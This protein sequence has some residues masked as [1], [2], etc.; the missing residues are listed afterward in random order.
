MQIAILNIAVLGLLVFLFGM[1]ASARPDNRLR[2]WEAGWV[3]VLVHFGVGI[4]NPADMLGAKI[5]FCASADTLVVAGIFFVVSTMVMREGVK[6]ALRVGSVMGIGTLV[7]IDLAIVAPRQTGI[8]AALAI[9]HLGAAGMVASTVRPRKQTVTR[10]LVMVCTLLTAGMLYGLLQGHSELVIY[11]LLC[12]V[13]LAAAIEFWNNSWRW[14]VGLN[15]TAGGLV[16][17][18]LVFPLSLL[19]HRLWPDLSVD[20]EFWNTP[21]L[22]VAI[23]MILVVLEDDTRAAQD[24]TRE[25]RLLFDANPHPLWVFE[26]AT[27]EFLDVNQAALDLHGYTREAFLRMKLVDILDP[28]LVPEMKLETA[29]PEPTIKRHS[30]H[31]CKDGRMLPL[32]V[33]AYPIEFR[34]KRCRFVLGTDLTER[35][36]LTQQLE[37]QA[38]H[39]P[40]TGLPNRLLFQEQL[41]AE[42]E[43]AGKS[44]GILA[45]LCVDL[46]R[47]KAVNDTY[48]LRIG[49]ECVKRAASILREH[50]EGSEALIARTGGGE[51]GIVLKHFNAVDGQ[52]AASE[53]RSTFSQPQ[54]IEGYRVQLSVSMGV[55]TCPQHGSDAPTL[56]RRAESAQRQSRAADDN[57]IVWYSTGLNRTTEEDGELEAF[58]RVQLER[59]GFHLVYQP[60]YAFDGSVRGLEALLRLDHPKHGAVSPAKFIPIAERAGLIV[61]IG[62]WVLEEVCRQLNLWRQA[63]MPL[64]PVAVNASGMQLMHVDFSTKVMETLERYG[65]DPQSI[66]MEVTETVAMRDVEAVA[67]RMA[68]L[69]ALGI[70][71]SIDDFGTGYSSLGRLHQLPITV[72]KVDRSFVAQLCGHNGTFTIVEAV[73]SMA[74]ALGLQVVAEGVEESSQLSCLQTLHCDLLQGYLLSRPVG[75]DAIPGLVTS[76]HPALLQV[77]GEC[78]VNGPDWVL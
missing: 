68:A 59:G 36:A 17:W 1:L 48:G 19:V 29:N 18:S 54:L 61:P 62:Q 40:L 39:D 65:I 49:D 60:L 28:A 63:G 67:E 11:G 32:E 4:W 73:I 50:F 75:P 37:H 66:H 24:L 78:P 23:G 74:H 31:L 46:I 34:G 38:Q 7:C 76:L 15:A 5:Q 9:G 53:V 45:A 33:N 30:R 44:G 47:L 13:F 77:S 64:V 22:V 72:L 35:E 27:K 70:R 14:T 52:K 8:L 2:C 43:R 51:F 16:A 57:P 58:M 41:A 71:F 42:V 25:Y 56:W 21:K 55:A 20:P 26:N 10:I 69:S 3:F 6:A 12:E